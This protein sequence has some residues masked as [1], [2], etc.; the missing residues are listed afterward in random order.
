MTDPKFKHIS[1][2]QN[3]IPWATDKTDGTIYRLHGD[4][5]VPLGWVTDKVG[6]AEVI[7]AVNWGSAWCVNKNHEIWY[8]E[9]V[10]SGT[11][12]QVPTYSGRA[13]ARTISVGGDGSVWYA[14]TDGTIYRRNVDA[15]HVGWMPDKI[16]KAEVIAAVD[17]GNLWCVNKD[18][19]IWHLENAENLETGG[20]WTQV[21]THSGRADAKM[22]SAGYDGV[23][24]V[25]MDG[26]LIQTVPPGVGVSLG[27]WRVDSGPGKVDVI[28]VGPEGG[29]W[30]LTRDG[31][32]WNTVNNKWEQFVGYDS[33]NWKYT[34]KSGDHLMAIVRKEFNLRDPQDTSEINRLVDLI[35]AQNAGITRDRI[36]AGDNLKLN[37]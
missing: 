18:H 35:V 29:A 30:C 28:A 34:V 7:A 33:I 26:T 22:I 24:Y 6:K 9:N 2:G 3:H 13:D 31:Q 14:G 1:L 23:F 8:L 11:W 32:A 4:A 25:Q 10:E 21:P 37:Y 15:G 17:S 27:R 16:G 36:N 5:S 20:T 12:I 19:E